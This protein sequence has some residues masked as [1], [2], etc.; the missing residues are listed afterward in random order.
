[1]TDSSTNTG[2][3]VQRLSA[4]RI[5]C[6]VIF[7]QEKVSP[8]EEQSIRKLGAKVNLPGFRP[9]MA[10]I[11]TLRDK[12][13]PEHILEETIHMLL[14]E[15]IEQLVTQ[16]NI[17]P[18]IHPKVEAKNREPLTLTIT[19]V[20][21]PEVSVKANKI[22]VE[23]KKPI[24]ED[25]EI[26]RM[27]DY[28]LEK[29]QTR[30][31]VDRASKEGDAIT[32][33]F[34]G[35]DESKNEIEGTRI[36]GHQAV[37][38]S[39]VLI[40]GFEEELKGLKKGE[41]KSFTITFPEKYHAEHLQGKPAMFHVKVLKVEEVQKPEL[42]DEFAKENL[43]AESAEDFR[44]KVKESMME[45]EMQFVNQ[46]NEEVLM[47]EIRKATKVELAPELVDE[48]TRAILADTEKQLQ[49]RNVTLKQWLE[50][51]GK[52]PEEMQKDLQE[53]A[54]KRLTL[55]LGVQQLVEDQKIE[56]PEEEMQNAI[57]SLLAPLTTDE[58]LQ[59]EQAYQP[60]RQ[61]YEQLKWQKK[62]EKVLD[63]FLK[64]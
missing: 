26:Q 54:V 9:G 6:T 18:I 25:K 22:K 44:T 1:M 40:P 56:V 19:F 59:M 45:Q 15:T 41:Q 33:D 31:E 57:Q 30:T 24:V 37:I 64:A 47:E 11:E 17:K 55:R 21:K 5:E 50:Q 32:M 58:R 16:H 51:S 3:T 20:E 49:R 43:E 53:Q 62:V 35:E 63:G 23:S 52:K 38:G 12:I 13:H 27:M 2:I 7:P 28:I 14:P 34:Y 46:K 4:G 8:A 29:H 10:P 39:K 48:E 61:A 60:G 36:Q 42:T